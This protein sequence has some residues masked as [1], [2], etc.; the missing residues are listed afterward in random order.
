VKVAATAVVAKEEEVTVAVAWEVVARAAAVKVAATAVV[1]K[2]A[3][4]EAM[5]ADGVQVTAAV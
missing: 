1:A 2:V 5:T 4:E 3:E